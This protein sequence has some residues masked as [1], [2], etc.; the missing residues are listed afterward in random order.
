[1]ILPDWLWIIL[2]GSVVAGACSLV[3][4]FLLLRRMAMLGDAISHA[5]LPGIAIAFLLTG[6]RSSLPMF[7]GAA[8]LGVITA[9]L[10]QVLHRNGRVQNDAAIG[11]TF[12]S[13]F[14]IGVI[15][16]S[17]YASQV[18]LDTDCVLYGVI[19][20]APLD[21]LQIG[22][23]DIGPRAFWQMAIIFALVA[24]AIV[25]L[26]KELKIT[27]FDPELATALGI[28][29]GLMHY[30]LMAL[31]SVTTVGAFEPVG[32]ILVVAMLVVP[33]A[34]AYLLTDDLKA[35]LWLSLLC[36]VLSSALGY[37]LAYRFDASVAGAMTVAGGLLF[38]GAF[39]FSPRHGVLTKRWSQRRLSQRV[40]GEDALQMLWRQA[41]STAG[42]TMNSAS[43]A[44]ATRTGDSAARRTL[45]GLKK[46]GL[47]QKDNEGWTLT[48]NGHHKAQ[49]LVHR[50]RVY[51]AFLENLGYP[52]DHVHDAAD[53]VEHFLPAEIVEEVDQAAGNPQTDPHGKII[54]HD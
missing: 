30:I 23:T 17:L 15:L 12:T 1:M 54:P 9:L 5:V 32:A 25:A 33:P 29:A 46:Q 50:H 2:I 45:E 3:G 4:C 44:N 10:V 43:L 20:L 36:G 34:T 49:E 37:W 21:T 24:A 28:N 47:T 19:E 31:V 11:V 18:D 27:S 35:M 40:A 51:E 41:E 14:A 6:S 8:A 39:V 48:Q 26:F 52:E 13:L 53:R 38:T 22:Q 16:I 42:A 7:L